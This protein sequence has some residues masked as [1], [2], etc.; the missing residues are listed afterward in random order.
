MNAAKTIIEN[1]NDKNLPGLKNLGAMA[2]NK[3]FNMSADSLG[4][5]A[6]GTFTPNKTEILKGWTQI[7]DVI[8]VLLEKK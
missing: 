1:T 8:R 3:E 2:S 5:V 6:H 4:R 7:E